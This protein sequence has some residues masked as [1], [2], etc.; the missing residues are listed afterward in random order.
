F[1]RHD[2][3]F[4]DGDPVEEIRA[5]LDQQAR[6]S[7]VGPGARGN[8]TISRLMRRALKTAAERK[9][10]LEKAG[11]GWRMGYGV[12]AP[13]ELLT[14]SGA[15][16]LIVSVLPMLE[17]LLLADKRWVFVPDS[18]TSRAFSTIAAALYPHE[19]AIIQRAKPTFEAIVNSGHYDHAHRAKLTKF[20]DKA[21]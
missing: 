18:L 16:A 8:D 15:G 9:S 17:E 19:I 3:D 12:P 13:I 10:L 2:C 5:I 20:V 1:M 11:P 7:R 6:R 14:G 21:G 4:R